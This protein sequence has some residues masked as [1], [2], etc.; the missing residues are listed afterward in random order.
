MC[1][2]GSYSETYHNTL[3]KIVEDKRVP[4]L[5]TNEVKFW[6]LTKIRCIV[7]VFCVNSA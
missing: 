2:I 5:K 3:I 7:L 4:N 6:F 1:L